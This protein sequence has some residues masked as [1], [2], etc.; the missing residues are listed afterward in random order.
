M[1]VKLTIVMSA[2]GQVMVP[3]GDVI[4]YLAARPE[5]NKDAKKLYEHVSHL[6]NQQ[7]TLTV[8]GGN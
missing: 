6:L 2:S 4:D 1:S 5:T 7:P 3:V 8:V